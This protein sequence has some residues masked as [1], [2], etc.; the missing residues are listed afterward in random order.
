MMKVQIT[1]NRT[2]MDVMRAALKAPRKATTITRDPLNP[3]HTRSRSKYNP[4]DCK[5]AGKR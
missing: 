4:L 1:P 5:R 2:I 3:K